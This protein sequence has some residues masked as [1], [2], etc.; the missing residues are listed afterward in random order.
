MHSTGGAPC[1][2]IHIYRDELILASDLQIAI[3]ADSEE[4]ETCG[5]LTDGKVSMF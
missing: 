2:A 4:Y 1:D 5:A 3:D